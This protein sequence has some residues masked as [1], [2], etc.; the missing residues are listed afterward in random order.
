MPEKSIGLT[1]VVPAYNEAASLPQVLPGLCEYCVKHNHQLIIVDDGSTDETAEI[2]EAATRD[3]V[4]LKVI[5]NKVNKGYGGAI[6]AGIQAVETELL[7][8]IDAD[9]QH[10]LNDIESLY[11]HLLAHDADMVVG[12]RDSRHDSPYRR[13]GKWLIR[14]T[15]RLLMSFNISDLNSG[16]KVYRSDLARQYIALCPDSMSFSDVITL[17][18]IKQKHLVL[19]TPISITARV[20]GSSTIN[21]MTA[22]E[23]I[24]EILHIVML[25][26]PSRIFLPLAVAF[27]GFG[28]LWGLPFL[29]RGEGVSSGTLLLMDTGLLFFLMGLLAEQLALIRRRNLH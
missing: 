21:T 13:L 23:T 12:K 25:F 22:V 3:C 8:T 6:K 20:S 26:N 24:M 7:I 4:N 1:I 29:L 14:A 18:F 27:A 17:V 28:L 10:S 15:A 19:E 11:Q 5:H 16:M 2:L 9:G